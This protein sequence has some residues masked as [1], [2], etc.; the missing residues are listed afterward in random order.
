MALPPD[1]WRNEQMFYRFRSKPCQRLV[2]SGFCEWHSQCQ[3]SHDPEWPRRPPNKH[4]YSP[5][6]C[7]HLRTISLANTVEVHVGNLCPSGGSCSFAHTKDEVLYH[8]QVFKTILCEEHRSVGGEQRG[9]RRKN[10]A[11]C[12]RYYCPFAHSRQELRTSPLS[13]EQREACINALGIFPTGG[14]CYVCTRSELSPVCPDDAVGRCYANDSGLP[15][16]QEAVAVPQSQLWTS[17]SLMLGPTDAF[18]ISPKSNAWGGLPWPNQPSCLQC[19]FM[20]L[21]ATKALQGV[22]AA[23]DSSCLQRMQAHD[24]ECPLRA[25]G[26]AVQADAEDDVDTEI[27]ERAVRFLNELSSQDSDSDD[28]VA[29]VISHGTRT[30]RTPGAACSPGPAHSHRGS[31]R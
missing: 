2:G 27:Y 12:H 5:V 21:S 13:G 19:D 14:C 8:P 23:N 30:S 3:F 6:L 25:V 20:G 15:P 4:T 29:S 7:P 17:D 9:A 28:H 26:H 22:A 10:R 18:L 11:R 31:A 24:R 1:F 16:T